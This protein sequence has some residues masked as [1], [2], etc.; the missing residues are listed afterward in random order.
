MRIPAAALVAT[1]AL[2]PMTAMAADPVPVVEDP[3]GAVAGDWPVDRQLLAVGAGAV[4]GIVAFNLISAPLGTVPLAGGALAAVP[5]ETALG[6]RMIAALSGG[7]GALLASEVYDNWTGEAHDYG[8][9]AALGLGAVG[10]VA[11][12]NLLAGTIGTMPYYAG[13]GDA[14]AAAGSGYASAAAQAASRVRV[15]ASAVMGAWVAD[16]MYRAE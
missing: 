8:Y 15:I 2:T 10:G 4:V 14:A 3:Q 1:L 11:V 9:L 12:G 6:S 16:W 7:A 5:Y 13:A